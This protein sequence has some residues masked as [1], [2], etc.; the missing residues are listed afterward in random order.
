MW[1]FRKPDKNEET[2]AATIEAKPEKPV[3]EEKPGF[4]WF[5]KRNKE[6]S[7]ESISDNLTEALPSESEIM[8]IEPI[9]PETSPQLSEP[10]SLAIEEEFRE[11]ETN[12]TTQEP[13]TISEESVPEP[14]LE[15]E[16]EVEPEAEKAGFFDR[17]KQGLKKTR[18]SFISGLTS[19][20]PGRSELTQEFWDELEELLILSDTGTKA[21]ERVLNELKQRAKAE[22]IKTVPQAIEAI[23][24]IMAEMLQ[25]GE[26]GLKFDDQDIT[27]FL[28][29][30]V[31][32]TGKTTSIA[33]LAYNLKHQGHNVLFS[34]ADTF[35]AAAIDQLEVWGERTGIPVI[36]QNP[37]ADPAA[38]VFDSIKAAKARGQNL[39]IA[40][41]AGRL[42]SKAPLMEELKKIKRVL[43][44]ELPNAPQE[45]LLVLDATTG[46]NALIQAK[47]FKDA[48]DLT[49]IILTKLDG[50]A[51]GGIIL[52]IAEEL[53]VPVK[54]IGIGEKITDLLEFN[55]AEY[56]NALFAENNGNEN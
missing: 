40:D 50:T 33:K 24:E 9:L 28:V 37:G 5:L 6:K 26:N 55:P 14:P 12:F 16:L 35:R 2:A 4:L 19:L 7:P 30:G 54:Y 8:A 47:A 23:K 11:L 53:N 46:Q 29:V 45:V 1:F 42:H 51:K 36:K 22:K 21:T 34:A 3:A 44:K 41:T 32:G 43:Q 48:V 25:V 10:A 20:I 17:L 15:M 27:V 13:L 31:N 38:V 39:V 18:D 52:S 56:V 49:G